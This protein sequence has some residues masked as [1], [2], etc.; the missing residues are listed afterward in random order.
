MVC[1]EYG[2]PR[3]INH[4]FRFPR[5][6]GLRPGRGDCASASQQ[7]DAERTPGGTQFLVEGGQRQIEA[8]SQFEISGIVEGKPAAFRQA[9]RS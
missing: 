9:E 4:S 2:A 5:K 7:S 1:R 8:L 6:L 3:A